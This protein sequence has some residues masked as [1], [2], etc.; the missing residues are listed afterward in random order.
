MLRSVLVWFLTIAVAVGAV[1]GIESEVAKPYKVPSAS[2]EPTL[3]C[4]QPTAGCEGSGDDR[5]LVNRL[6]YRLGSPKRGQIVVFRAPPSAIAA[7]GGQ[8]GQVLVKRLI[9]MPGDLV[10]E[11]AG[12][13]IVNGRELAE[14]YVDATLRDAKSG[15]WPR[16]GAGQYFF[17]GD[18]RADSCDSR[19][20]GTVGRAA[21]I[22]P[23]SVTFWPLIRFSVR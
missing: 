16:V 18:N 8:E 2:M 13:I 10:A 23:A 19:A 3:H 7:C 11:R 22:G 5:V 9:G 15:S 12:R 14:P 20:W 6:A 1:V 4:A 17:L 21:L